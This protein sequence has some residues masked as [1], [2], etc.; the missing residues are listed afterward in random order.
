[1]EALDLP[2]LLAGVL[3]GLAR[4]VS[5]AATAAAIRRQLQQG[6]S[7]PAAQLHCCSDLPHD[8]SAAAPPRSQQPACIPSALGVPCNP[9]SPPAPPVP[10]LQRK[11]RCRW[12]GRTRTPA[13]PPA[14]TPTCE[15]LR[16][17]R[18][19]CPRWPAC[20]QSCCRASRSACGR[21]RRLVAALPLG[22]PR[23]RLA[24]PQA[25]PA[26]RLPTAA[27]VTAS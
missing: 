25:A 4:Q 3:D 20:G 1:M 16:E 27:S 2:P 5:R 9:S 10:C 7:C 15:T 12:Y 22:P 24:L 17:R 11:A 21:R 8:E 13:W 19:R 23:P 6:A 14:W 18:R 26:A